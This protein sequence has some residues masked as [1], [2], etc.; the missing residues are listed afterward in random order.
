MTARLMRM[1]RPSSIL[2][3]LGIATLALVPAYADEPGA[4]K[5]TLSHEVEVSNNADGGRLRCEPSVAIFGDEIVVA[6]NDS[7]GGR[8][9]ATTG[10][11]VAWAISRDGGASYKFG[12]YLPAASQ[13]QPPSAA[14]SRLACD[15]EGNFYLLLL[16]WT[17]TG[18]AL[19]FYVMPRD[20]R[21]RWREVASPDKTT[22]KPSIDKPD[23]AVTPQGKVAVA[24]TR[25]KSIFFVVSNDAGLHWQPPLRISA[26]DARLRTGASVAIIDQAVV[27]AWLEGGGMALTEVWS[28]RSADGGASFAKPQLAY[29]LSG[30][31]R[32]PSGYALGVGP[33]GFI[34]NDVN[35]AGYAVDDGSSVF[36]LTCIEGA[37][38][39]ARVFLLRSTDGGR[40]WSKPQTVGYSPSGAAK[41]FSTIALLGRQPAILYYD[42]RHS[43][44]TAMTDVFLS[45]GI[46]GGSFA[47]RKLNSVSTDW[48][49]TPGDKEHAPIQRNFGDYIS[50]AAHGRRAVAVWTDGRSGAPRIWSRVIELSK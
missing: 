23:L 20:R 19:R 41:V 26:S 14:D 34:A 28:A 46:E 43:P 50:L 49:K 45:L 21:G 35:I 40:K 31:V 22:S 32:P 25:G 24:Y 8:L 42:R 1:Q 33:A 17:K 44:A 27:A 39:G 48:L 9:G 38:E 6:W 37:G 47:D 2:A 10:V 30:H 29:T 36:S 7:Y 4:V 11:A 12:G 3:V 16:N 13:D 15:A 18:H 5:L